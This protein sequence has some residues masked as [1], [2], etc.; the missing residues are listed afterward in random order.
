VKF[1]ATVTRQGQPRR[2]GGPMV[3][4][5]LTRQV[6]VNRELAKLTP[7]RFSAAEGRAVAA[8]TAAR[9][10]GHGGQRVVLT[11]VRANRR[12]EWRSQNYGISSD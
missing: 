9:A 6:R 10:V 12:N 4:P 11:V 7:A 3:A 2:A 1:E 5:Q 8:A